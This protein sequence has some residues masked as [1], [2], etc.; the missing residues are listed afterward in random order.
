MENSWR[1]DNPDA[2]YPRLGIVSRDNG[3]KMSSWWVE[4]GAYIRLKSMQ[5]GYTLP[6][7]WVTPAGIKKYVFMFLVVTC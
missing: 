7:Q 1:P 4:N 6:S 2:E 5:V 3:G